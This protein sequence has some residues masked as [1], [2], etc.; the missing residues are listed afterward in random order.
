MLEKVK[1][2]RKELYEVRAIVGQIADTIS[3]QLSILVTSFR[4]SGNDQE[5]SHILLGQLHAERVK[6]VG[7][8]ASLKEVEFKV[9][10]QFGQDGIVQYLTQHIE[11]P[12]KVFVEFGVEDYS[13][14]TTRF[15][16]MKDNWSGLIMD[17]SDTYMEGVR[18]SELHWR[19]DLT[20]KGAFITKDNINDLISS[21]TKEQDIGLLVID[22]DGNDYWI[23]E[24][25][26]VVKP[27]IVMC[28]YNSAFGSEAEVVIP[29]AEDFERNKAHYSGLYFG[30][31]V[32]ALVKLG[33]QK[34]YSFVGCN[35][36]GN[37]AVFVRT[38]VLKAPLREAT[39][40][41]GYVEA[42]FRDSRNKSGEL[43]FLKG[44][45]KLA[46]MQDMPVVDLNT[47][48]QITIAKLYKH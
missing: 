15:L 24:A 37:D 41:Q 33:K 48:K 27:R 44:A 30:A 36:N 7:E 29:Y 34:G 25:I 46:E 23:W 16:L 43:T 21:Y 26:D 3:H 1:N 10:S 9:F 13:E 4:K 5:V 42:K 6:H 12:N 2:I 20:A 18:K 8:I 31:S 11:I 14:S 28:E 17:G 40:A 35:S 45:A 38:D 47:G 22:L 32:A 19:Y 39:P